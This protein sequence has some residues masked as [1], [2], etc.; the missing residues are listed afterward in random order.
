LNVMM[1]YTIF[2]LI[3]GL[4]HWL[5]LRQT[6]VTYNITGW[7]LHALRLWFLLMVLSP[8]LSGY[9]VERTGVW[10]AVTFIWM[11][12]VF[13]LFLGAV[14]LT[15]FRLLKITSVTRPLFTTIVV[16]SLAACI[17][18]VYQARHPIV[19]EVD[20]FVPKERLGPEPLRLALISDAHLY[21]VEAESRL[22]RI[23]KA[24]SSVDYDILLSAGD[25]IEAGIH[26]SEWRGPA[27][28]LAAVKPR[29]GKYAVMGN[30]EHYADYAAGGNIS[31]RFHAASG[32]DLLV[33]QFSL[34]NDHVV[35]VGV[36]DGGHV[37]GDTD[38]EVQLLEQSN[39][40]GDKIV[41]FLKHRPDV[42]PDSMG[43]FDLMMSGHTHDGQMW[44]F[45]YI[46]KAFYP[47]IAGLY[48]IG[49]ES[50]LYTTPGVGT[51]GPPMRIGA[52]P[53]ITLIHLKP[54]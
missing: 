35:L 39:P 24:L 34:I 33:D 8:G 25:L 18:G 40:Q 36:P 27:E 43:K 20:V 28:L 45:T 4:M 23:L 32:F 38:H 16:V 11:G 19:R 12:L 6:A 2:T 53:E 52:Q 15:P 14:L 9:F 13:Y 47:Y 7:G 48:D 44:P 46:V 49:R 31:A 41:L 22:E 51:W 37:A 3:Y 26:G 10:P 30:H 5:V 42:P 21:S 50:R 29:L 17:W 54:R 1:F